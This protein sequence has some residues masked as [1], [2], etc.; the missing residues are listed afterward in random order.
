[1]CDTLAATQV[2]ADKPDRELSPYSLGYIEGTVA[3]ALLERDPVL[4]GYVETMLAALQADAGA[5]QAA[6]PSSVGSVREVLDR[7]QLGVSGSEAALRGL[8]EGRIG[9]GRIAARRAVVV[10]GALVLWHWCVTKTALGDL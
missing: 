6:P 3:L 7:L 5:G 2:M 10:V 8:L 1:M 9:D 4:R